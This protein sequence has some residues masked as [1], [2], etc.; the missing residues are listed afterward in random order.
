LV[1][2]DLIDALP[3]ILRGLKALARDA[4]LLANIADRLYRESP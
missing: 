2:E 3:G 1:A 4:G